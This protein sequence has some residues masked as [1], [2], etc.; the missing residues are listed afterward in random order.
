MEPIEGSVTSAF[1][2]QTP[3]KYPKENILQKK[4]EFAALINSYKESLCNYSFKVIM[5]DRRIKT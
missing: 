5:K 1:K 2:P 3:G 4:R